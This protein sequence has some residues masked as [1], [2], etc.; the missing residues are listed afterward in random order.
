MMGNPGLPILFF[1]GECGVC[2]RTV[3]F[4]LDRD[5]RRRSL[6]FASLQGNTA[7]ELLRSHPGLA[8]VDSLI[9]FDPPDATWGR[10]E[11]YGGGGGSGPESAGPVGVSGRVQVRSDAVIMAGRYL[12][13]VWALLAGIA[14]L[15]PRPIRDRAYDLFAGI[16][17]KIPGFRTTCRLP[18]PE[19]AARFLG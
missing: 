5:R 1:D 13:G 15:V 11:D 6:R 2:T 14:A 16:R 10:E 17:R 4:L 12:G 19:E 18:T 3:R 8:G 9:W 7:R